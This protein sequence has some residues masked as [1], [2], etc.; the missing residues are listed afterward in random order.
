MKDGKQD[1]ITPG[2]TLMVRLVPE[3]ALLVT[4][5]AREPAAARKSYEPGTG[6]WRATRNFHVVVLPALRV[7]VSHVCYDSCL[8]FVT[9]CSQ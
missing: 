1:T 6:T 5:S 3:S 8:A 4:R 7:S 2:L 9:E